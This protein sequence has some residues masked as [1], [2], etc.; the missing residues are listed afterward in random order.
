MADWNILV[1]CARPRPG[2]QLERVERGAHGDD[3]FADA[4]EPAAPVLNLPVTGWATNDTTPDLSWKS[5]LN[6]ATFKYRSHHP[7]PRCLAR[8]IWM[9]VERR[10]TFLLPLWRMVYI[11]GTYEQ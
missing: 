4:A 1:A 5:V 7:P 3:L 10:H 2:G 11:T 8:P 6:G 9:P